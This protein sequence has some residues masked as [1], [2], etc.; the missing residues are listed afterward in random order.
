MA[1][2]IINI[3]Q[4]NNCGC[5]VKCQQLILRDYGFI[6][7]EDDLYE[8]AKDNGWF[9]ETEGVYMRDNGKLL[10]CFGVEYHHSQYN[11]IE[12]VVQELKMY[13][14]VMVNINSYKIRV[15]NMS[16]INGIV[17]HAVLLEHVDVYGKVVYITDPGTGNMCEPVPMVMF[18]NAWHDSFCY[19]LA[20]DNPAKYYYDADMQTLKEFINT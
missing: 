16:L 11:T 2:G 20:T 17:P 13:H 8:I 4:S 1:T 10:G 9:L 6:I 18:E 3:K 15:D 12:S 5:A 14:K 19:M 7:S